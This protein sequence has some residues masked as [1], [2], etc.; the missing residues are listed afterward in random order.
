MFKYEYTVNCG[1]ICFKND[2]SIR[3]R[4][5]KLHLRI[6]KLVLFSSNHELEWRRIIYNKRIEKKATLLYE[7]T[8][9]TGSSPKLCTERPADSVFMI[10]FWREACFPKYRS[11]SV[12]EVCRR[13]QGRSHTNGGIACTQTDADHSNDNHW[14]ISLSWPLIVG[15]IR[16]SGRGGNLAIRA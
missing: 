16:P 9:R 15:G 1:K 8:S 2:D 3:K 5:R 13:F 14:R 6:G 11:E 10:I 12:T 7:L 4:K